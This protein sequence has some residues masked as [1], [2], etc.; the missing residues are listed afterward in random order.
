M[1]ALKHTEGT[2]ATPVWM[3]QQP[4]GTEEIGNAN[5]NMI[6]SGTTKTGRSMFNVQLNG[7]AQTRNEK[8]KTLVMRIGG[9]RKPHTWPTE[10]ISASVVEK[11]NLSFLASTTLTMTGILLDILSKVRTALMSKWDDA[12]RIYSVGFATT[13]TPKGSK[14]YALTATAENIGMVVSALIRS[15]KRNDQS[16]DVGPSGPKRTPS[17]PSKMMIWSDLAGDCKRSFLTHGKDDSGI[18]TPSEQ[19]P[20]I[21]LNQWVDGNQLG[22]AAGSIFGVKK[23]IFNSKDFGV[24][25]LDTY[26]I[27]H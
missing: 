1:S 13:I 25:A 20:I 10:D 18:A 14:F 7:I 2:L 19:N 15:R 8:V 24:I 27:A 5:T 11:R 26:A 3:R 16:K 4:N 22:V 21:Q 6:K 17:L 23:T 12:E 9:S